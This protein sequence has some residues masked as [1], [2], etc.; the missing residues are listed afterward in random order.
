[1]YLIYKQIRDQIKDE[2]RGFALA[3]LAGDESPQ[4]NTGN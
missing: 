3:N 2:Y 1:M 4:V